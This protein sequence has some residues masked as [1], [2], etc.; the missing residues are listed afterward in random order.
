MTKETKK[1]KGYGIV[2]E[3]G[4]LTLLPIQD[5][6]WFYPVY[7]NWNFAKRDAAEGETVVK[8]TITVEKLKNVK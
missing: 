2:S 8:V 3:R 6:G 7:Q 1:I 4:K 5:W